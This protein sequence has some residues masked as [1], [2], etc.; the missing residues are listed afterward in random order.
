M[1][2]YDMKKNKEEEN[3]KVNIPTFLSPGWTTKIITG[4]DSFLR[5]MGLIFLMKAL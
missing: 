2:N 5:A 4:F 1:N 3:E